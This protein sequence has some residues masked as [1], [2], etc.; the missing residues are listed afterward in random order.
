MSVKPRGLKENLC[1]NSKTKVPFLMYFWMYK[2]K[3]KLF[4]EENKVPEH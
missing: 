1:W 2:W 4:S 3:N